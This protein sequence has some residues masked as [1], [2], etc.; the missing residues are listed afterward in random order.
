MLEPVT[1]ISR[2]EL[3]SQSSDFELGTPQAADEDA[4]IP[5]G[6]HQQPQPPSFPQATQ[7]LLCHNPHNLPDMKKASICDLSQKCQELAGI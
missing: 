1:I 7:P 2:R 6:Y 5:G 3:R 4:L